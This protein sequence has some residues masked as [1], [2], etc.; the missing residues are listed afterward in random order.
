MEA[1]STEE[2]IHYGRFDQALHDML[3]DPNTPALLGRDAP[4]VYNDRET[5]G[6]GYILCPKPYT[7]SAEVLYYLLR[8]E[9]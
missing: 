6:M 9:N 7:I 5:S 4:P 8:N 3:N 1:T 2:G